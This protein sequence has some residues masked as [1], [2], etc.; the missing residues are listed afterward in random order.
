MYKDPLRDI[1]EVARSFD[2]APEIVFRA[3]AEPELVRRW[4]RPGPEVRLDVLAYE[5]RPGGSYRFA[6]SMPDAPTMR[7]NGTFEAIEPP[8]RIRFTWNI[9]PPDEH[10]GIRSVVTVDIRAAG[11]DSEVSIR[12]EKLSLPGAAARHTEGWRGALA[13]LAQ[14][15]S[16]G[17][18][19]PT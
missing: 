11:S 19:T 3:F 9:E 18:E 5:F 10:A 2:A 16:Q 13:A 17:W 6:Y 4:L 15:I 12:H 8:S 14:T 7:V 1:A